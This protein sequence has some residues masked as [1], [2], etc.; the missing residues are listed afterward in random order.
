MAPLAAELQPVRAGLEGGRFRPLD[1]AA[2]QAIDATV[3]QILE[4]IGLSQAPDSGI[5]YMT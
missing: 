2:V 3:F 4:D 1:P 5:G